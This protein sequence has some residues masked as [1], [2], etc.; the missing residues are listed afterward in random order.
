MK[1]LTKII[2]TFALSLSLVAMAENKKPV[3]PAAPMPAATPAATAAQPPAPVP[4]LSAYERLLLLE[5][6][7][8]LNENKLTGQLAAA[9][10]TISELQEDRYKG[11]L[12]NL[13]QQ[14]A[15]AHNIPSN[16]SMDP[17]SMNFVPPPAKTV[18]TPATPATPAK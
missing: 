6:A 16:W 15:A 9:N 11:D 10:K 2:T 3:V 1:I 18:A 12:T 17:N 7:H 4:T 8:V 14:L 13:I 5:K